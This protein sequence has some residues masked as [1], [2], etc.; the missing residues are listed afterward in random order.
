[1]T[2][3]ELLTHPFSQRLTWTLAHFLWQGLLIA[4]ALALVVEA[5]RIRSASTRYSLS[6]AALLVM[7]MMLPVTWFAL[8]APAGL[9]AASSVANSDFAFSL[10]DGPV[11]ISKTGAWWIT[12]QP[13]FFGMWLAGCGLLNLRLAVGW[14]ATH[15]LLSRRRPLPREV[16]AQLAVIGR[17]FQ[18]SIP[19]VVFAS[20]Q[21]SQALAV[22]FFRPVVLL[23]AAWLLELPPNL[24]QA[25]VA[26]ELAHLRRCDLWV[27]LL[28]RVAEAI[29][30]YHPAIW[31]L[32]A[33]L[34]RERELCCDELA[35]AATGQR[36]EYVEALELTARWALVDGRPALAAG[37]FGEGKMNLLHRVRCVLGIS[38]ERQ[39]TY[40]PAS[41]L[42]GGL[43]L[44]LLAVIYSANTSRVIADDERPKAKEGERREGDRP[45]E[46]EVRRDADKPAASEGD[47]FLGRTQ[48][49]PRREGD[50]PREGEVRRDGDRPRTEGAPRD[51]ERRPDVKRP[52]QPREGVREPAPPTRPAGSGENAE[53]MA[54]IKQLRAE[55]AELR[56]EVTR[57]RGSSVMRRPGE[58]D[59]RVEPR[60]EGDRPRVEGDRPRTEGGDR[61]RVEGDRPRTEGGDRPRPDAV[62]RE[63]DR[64]KTEADRPKTEERREGGDR[65]KAEGDRR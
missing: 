39:A 47:R 25:V 31:W 57:L 2:L 24:L 44:A 43:S 46:G 14:C 56:A 3:V 55:V 37:F 12:L 52:D 42:L 19:A 60:R 5:L 30:F 26:H 27:N 4:V 58:G 8:A 28:Q 49:E 29:L 36:V 65:P 51:G 50:R 64:P 54:V 35:V 59:N 6:L 41:L 21:V 33:R 1:M 7:L 16:S 48:A 23:P 63:G 20:E 38:S 13:L 17:H 40:W 45:R 11:P 62:R 18:Q 15:S 34:R 22:G 10:A 53:L 32:S 61:P 9:P